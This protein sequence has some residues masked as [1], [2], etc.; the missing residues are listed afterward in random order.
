MTRAA[1]KRTYE[2]PANRAGEDYLGPGQVV[3]VTPTEVAVEIRAGDR[4]RAH[5]ALSVPYEASVGDV[6]LVIGRDDAHYVIGVLHGRGKTSLSFQGAV[7][8]RATGGPLT[9]SSDE[10]VLVHGP[11]MEIHAG[12]LE[13]FATTVVEKLGSLYQ[14][15]RDALD[16]HAGR[17]QTVVEDTSVMTAKNASILT[18]ETMSINGDEIHLG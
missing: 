3:A 13:V 17:M 5:M 16:V 14:R 18:E 4:V 10:R 7:D 9:L 2:L 11:A 12:K 6:L 1:A 15:V 8:L